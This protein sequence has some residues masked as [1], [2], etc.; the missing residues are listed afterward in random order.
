MLCLY[1][2]YIHSYLNYTNT[3]WC[4]TNITYLKKFQSDQTHATEFSC[5]KKNCTSRQ[6]LKENNILN[7]YQLNIFNDLL[8]QDRVNTTRFEN[9]GNYLEYRRN[10]LN[11]IQQR[12]KMA[13]S[14]RTFSVPAGACV[15]PLIM[16][17]PEN[18]K[19]AETYLF[20][21]DNWNKRTI[22]EICQS[23][24]KQHKINQLYL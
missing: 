19:L 9:C 6:H 12:N 14:I 17:D 2:P 24:Q 15:I 11:N 13:H 10:I 21:V 1:C 22:F 5:T 7:I 23:W 16:H 20:K 3:S 8:F 4:S 18:S